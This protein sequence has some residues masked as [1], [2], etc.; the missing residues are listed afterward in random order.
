MGKFLTFGQKRRNQVSEFPPNV[1]VKEEDI[2]QEDA[3][4]PENSEAHVNG[5]ERNEES[6]KEDVGSDKV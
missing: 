1:I 3:N 5:D 2:N 6:S 4:E